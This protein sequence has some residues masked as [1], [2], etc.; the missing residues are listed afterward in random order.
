MMPRLPSAVSPERVVLRVVFIVAVIG[1]GLWVLYKLA[2]LVLVLIAA[3]LFAYVIAPVVK[4]VEA[5]RIIAG[6]RRRLPRGAAIAVTYLLIAGVASSGVALLLPRV[7]QQID[8]FASAAPTYTQSV[9]SWEHGW[10]RYYGRLRMPSRLRESIDHAV[11]AGSE[12][13]VESARESLMALLGVISALPWLVLIPV[14]AFFML[15]DGGRFRRAFL[16]VLPHDMRLVTHRLF[17]DVNTTLAAYVRAQL[18]ACG[19]VGGLCG[20]GFAVLGIP[21]AVVLGIL[22]GVLELIPM[23][24]PLVVAVIASVV[25]ASGGV[26][27]VLRVIGFLVILRGVEDY[28]IYP[29]LVRRGLHLNPMAVIV[30]VLAG[31]ELHGVVGMF[32]A[33]PSLAVASVA[34]RHWQTSRGNG[35]GSGEVSVIRT[36]A[37]TRPF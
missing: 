28:V 21:Y 12:G 16:S 22:A 29:R 19:V 7:T 1:F 32:L 15:K 4:R 10:S 6:S 34:F 36:A 37:D 26:S 24:G 30:A 18:L 20:L 11:A 3:A 9:L 33:V 2:F 35:R 13:A 31:A 8:D 25:A 17:E 23:V 5:P 27:L 14:L